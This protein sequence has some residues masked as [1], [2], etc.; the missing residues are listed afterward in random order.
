MNRMLA[1]K[2]QTLRHRFFLRRRISTLACSAL[3][4]WMMPASW[5]W[6]TN[7]VRSSIEIVC[8][9]YFRSNAFL[10]S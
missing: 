10:T 8:G 7:R 9:R 3:S 5:S 6:A 2:L 4:I 1:R